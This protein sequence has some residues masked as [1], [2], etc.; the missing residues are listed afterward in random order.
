MQDRERFVRYVLGE[1]VDRPPYWLY[2]GPWGTT[3]Q[4]WERENKP[5]EVTDHRMAFPVDFAPCAVPVNAGPCPVFAQNMVDEGDAYQYTDTWGIRRRILKGRESMPEFLSFPVQD[6]ADW[7]RYKAERLDPEHPDRLAGDWRAQVA[8]W[9]SEGRPIQLGYFPDVGFFGGLRW[10]LGDEQCLTA[11]YTDPDL[12]QEIMDHLATLYLHVFEAV[13]R[14]CR[15]DVIH[16][17]EDMCGRN[18]PLISP[19]LWE[20]FMGPPYRRVRDFAERHGIPVISVDTDGDPDLIIPPMIAAGVNLLFPC[21]VTAGCDVNVMRQKH[22]DI[23]LMGGIDKRVLATGPA[24][25][26]AELERIRPALEYGRYIPDLDHLVPDDVPWEH[27]VY[28]AQALGRLLGIEAP[29]GG[30]SPF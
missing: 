25:I 2:W 22:P 9:E 14:E 16:I 5:P 15:V 26:D 23:A 4:R 7:V 27:Y 6:A 21:E 3:W 19:A 8:V 12:V 30:R 24:A 20:A 11:F 28:Y 13:V 17:W 1:D 29:S 10:L 18:G